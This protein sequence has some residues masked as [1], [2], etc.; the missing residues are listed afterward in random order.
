[1]A[2]FHCHN[3]SC[4]PLPLASSVRPPPELE[5]I[6]ALAKRHHRVGTLATVEGLPIRCF[7]F[8]PS[9]RRRPALLIVAGLHGIERIGTHVAIAYLDALTARLQWD[10]L[11]Q[12]SLEQVR[13]IVVP[14][15]NPVGMALGQRANGQG[16]DLMRNAPD[17][18]K[19]ATPL[20]GGQR[21]TARLP[22]FMGAELQTESS[23]LMSLV[24][25]ELFET[26][27]SI[28]L[29][30]HSGFGVIDRLWYPYARTREA[31]PDQP[32]ID[33]LQG[34]LDRSLPNH[35]YRVEQ[36]ARVYTIRGD[37]W[38]YLYDRRR[39]RGSGIL[40]PLT[41]EMGSWS[42]VRKNPLQ[43]F[44]VEGRFNPI[45][46]HRLRRT[47]RRHIPIIEFLLHAAAS[48]RA[49]SLYFE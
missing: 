14:L 31:P 22:W 28:A 23:A 36:T 47:L 7:R 40:L 12:R 1:M 44:S 3:A 25:N 29:D 37:L 48:H 42:W 46:P 13:L 21:M 2:R 41:L 24:E 18:A 30:L 38:D 11:L 9:D 17:P 49:W 26:P 19:I 10:E 43:G 39:Q 45:K 34:L 5:A 4:L 16:V 15:L 27:A 32:A 6:D 8:G 33:A 35:V 20:V